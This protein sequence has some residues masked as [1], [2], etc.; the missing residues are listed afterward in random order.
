MDASPEDYPFEPTMSPLFDDVALRQRLDD[1]DASTSGAGHAADDAPDRPGPVDWNTLT[2]EE[3][4]LAWADLNDWV[5][6]LRDTYGLPPTIVPPLWHWELSALHT[7]WLECYA[8]DGSPSGP[9]IWARDFRD[10]KDRLREMVASCGTRLDRDR[11]TRR[12][13]WPGEPEEQPAVEHPIVDRAKDFA[14]FVA[15]DLATRI[16]ATTFGEHV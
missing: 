9:I 7:H 15:D 5:Y 14:A 10:A 2:R 8:P 6:W 11:P 12:T 4:A 3:A 1:L 13:A 16:S